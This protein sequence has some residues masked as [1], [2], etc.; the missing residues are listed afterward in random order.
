[1]KANVITKMKN[2]MLNFTQRDLEAKAENL[3]TMHPD[4]VPRFRFLR[5]VLWL[6][7]MDTAY[8]AANKNL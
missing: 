1:M 4:P 3:L 8:R 7:P 2:T 6:E 5:D